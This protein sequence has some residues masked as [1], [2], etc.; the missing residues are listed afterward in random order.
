MADKRV[1]TSSIPFE[2]FT[3]SLSELLESSPYL[4]VRR[5]KPILVDAA[6]GERVTA[7]QHFDFVRALSYVLATEH[8]VRPGDVVGLFCPNHIRLIAL[9]HALMAVGA[10]VTPMN[11]A[12]TGED[13]REQLTTARARLVFAADGHW[14]DVATRAVGGAVAVASFEQIVAAARATRGRRDAVPLAAASDAALAY[15]CFSSGTTGK[16]KGVMTSHSNLANN[17]L[18]TLLAESELMGPDHVVGAFLPQSHIFGL[19]MHVYLAVYAAATVVVF[20]SFGLE[21]FLAATVT[22]GITLAHVVPPVV[23]LLA[24][25][26]LVARFPALTETLRT[27]VS[28]AAPLSA[29]LALALQARFDNALT[30]VQGYGLTETS[31]VLHMLPPSRPD[32]RAGSI[33]RLVPGV[34]ARL[35]DEAGADV[36]PGQ[37]G[38]ILVQ[39]VNVMMGYLDNA[40]ATAATFADGWLR[41]GDVGQVDADGYW[42]IVD[43][44]KELIKS[45]G[46]QVAPSELEAL[47]L[48]HA[49]VLDAA[50]V[51]VYDDAAATEQPRAFVVLAAGT[52][53]GAVK[54]WLDGQVARHKRLWGGLVVLDQIPKSPSGKILRRVLRARSGDVVH[55]GRDAR[56]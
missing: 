5:D 45:K 10:V 40:A 44:A 25:S 1:Y 46:F 38:E 16:F 29:S 21:P 56:L 53:P 55:G 24:K 27:L 39:G 50:V 22:Y 41:T 3:G 47:L 54:R 37:P 18:Q 6:T 49:G 11:I 9:N 43:R 36:A 12:Y 28:G 32:S 7:A 48:T 14:L 17:T 4:R 19:T 35:V 13:V 2:P 30:V 52:E 20:P 51:G 34:R 23:V 26:P 42:T 15:L 8:G 33:G 31:P